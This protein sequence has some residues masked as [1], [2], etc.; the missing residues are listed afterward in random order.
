MEEK[1]NLN[2]FF[3]TRTST[4]GDQN[5]KNSSNN[6]LWRTR[7]MNKKIIIMRGEKDYLPKKA[8]KAEMKNSGFKYIG[9][10]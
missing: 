2:F 9:T 7:I 3:L 10:V 1:Q 8:F 6:F 5:V 4:D